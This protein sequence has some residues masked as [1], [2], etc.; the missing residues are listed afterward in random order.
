LGWLAKKNQ[1]RDENNLDAQEKK[2]FVHTK[3]VK[4]LVGR[5]PSKI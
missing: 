3:I 1:G 5:Q 4:V 2:L